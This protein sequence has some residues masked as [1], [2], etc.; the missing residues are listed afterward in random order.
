[1]ESPARLLG[2]I[3]AEAKVSEHQVRVAQVC[4]A[5]AKAGRTLDQAAASMQRSR[6]YLQRVSRRWLIDFADY[7]PYARRDPRPAPIG[8]LT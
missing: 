4:L 2:Q 5:Y 1:M 7:R 6:G 8:R 3:A